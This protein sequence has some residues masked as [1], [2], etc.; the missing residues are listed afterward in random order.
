VPGEKSAF[1][2]LAVLDELLWPGEV[3]APAD[4]SGCATVRRIVD[5]GALP[6][7]QELMGREYSIR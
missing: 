1:T 2:Y 4:G 3:I 5:H 7:P 6:M